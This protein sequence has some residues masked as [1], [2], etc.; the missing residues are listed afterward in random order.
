MG[1]SEKLVKQLFTLAR[2]KAPSVVF[3]DE[4]DSLAGKRSEKDNAGTRG[5]KTEFLV[6]MQG[7]G[8]NTTGVLL[9][10]SVFTSLEL[11]RF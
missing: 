5:L 7:V 11:P 1:E 8:N 4:I 6:Q 2:E 3:I 10:A 9:L